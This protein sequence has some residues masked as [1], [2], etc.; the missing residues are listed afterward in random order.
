MWVWGVWIAED[1]I[2]IGL[3]YMCEVIHIV[4]W[5]ITILK[6]S[7]QSCSDLESDFRGKL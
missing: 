5:E 6:R 1:A 4:G 7:T 2:H 3:G